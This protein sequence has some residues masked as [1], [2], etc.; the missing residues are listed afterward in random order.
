MSEKVEK[1]TKKNIF[2]F[3]FVFK[4][5]EEEEEAIFINNRPRIFFFSFSLIDYL[6]ERK[7]E[8][9]SFF[10]KYLKLNGFEIKKNFR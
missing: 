10:Q 9:V 2:F 5:N 3:Y 1:K 7:R 6:R 8:I 4:N